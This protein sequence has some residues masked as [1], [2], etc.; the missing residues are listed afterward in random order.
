MTQKSYYI[1]SHGPFYYDDA[2]SYG[3]GP[4]SGEDHI[5]L[6]AARARVTEAPTL[7]DDAFRLF[8]ANQRI[9]R[10]IEV[11]DIDNPT[12]LTSYD[13]EDE[14]TVVMAYEISLDV[15]RVTFYAYDKNVP[16]GANS[17]YI[18]AAATAGTYWIAVA[19]HNIDRNRQQTALLGP[20]L[21]VN[22]SFATAEPA[23]GN[24]SVG[25]QWSHDAADNEMDFSYV[26]SAGVLS[27]TLPIVQG[28]FYRVYY[29]MSKWTSGQVVVQV[30]GS[31]VTGRSSV[32]FAVSTPQ[33]GSS[34][35]SIT[36]TGDSGDVFS[37][38]NV[39]VREVLHIDFVLPIVSEYFAYVRLQQYS[40]NNLAPQMNFDKYRGS[41]TSPSTVA[42]GDNIL[43]LRA[44]AYDGSNLLL[45]G[46]FRMDSL[47]APSG[48]FM[49]TSFKIEADDGTVRRPILYGTGH[50]VSVRKS[51]LESS[52]ANFKYLE[53]AGSGMIMA[54]NEVGT[55]GSTGSTN[56]S[57]GCYYD[58][59][60]RF[61]GNAKGVSL[62]QYLG[63]YYFR[64]SSTTPSKGSALSW[65]GSG[66]LGEGVLF[67]NSGDARFYDEV[68]GDRIQ[69]PLSAIT[70]NATNTGTQYYYAGTWG[71]LAGSYTYSWVAI[72]DGS[73]VG[74]SYNVNISVTSVTS[75]TM[76][77]M[78]NG[79]VVWS[80]AITNTVGIKTGAGNQPRDTD[81]F[82][83]GD[84]IAV[85]LNVNHGGTTSTFNVG[86]MSFIL[87]CYYDD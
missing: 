51:V 76:E 28:R 86:G 78:I 41:I 12:E 9:L 35:L 5:G 38:T 40:S 42:S 83:S 49:Q 4:E 13:G 37:I 73:L 47:A 70:L 21:I 84:T 69:F 58:G 61:I 14:S 33:A 74:Y 18:V 50:G 62:I 85:R 77:M 6:L 8:D 54:A 56:W 63:Q 23:A 36:F 66:A 17:P 22:G 25:S 19:G 64:V 15:N 11:A 34:P 59:S 3:G 60:Y 31:D 32:G 46:R 87:D 43:D 67:E 20:E 45:V 48:G 79:T 27:Q 52:Q 16:S 80:T 29:E 57:N 72:R 55:L 71:A 10:P 75:V 26:S 53:I 30:G 65:T 2:S 24:W 82:N 44:N 81:Q 68:H 1:G 39:S 7:S